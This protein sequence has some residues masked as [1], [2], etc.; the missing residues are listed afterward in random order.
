MFIFEANVPKLTLA[1]SYCFTIFLSDIKLFYLQYYIG[2]TILQGER[3][4][5]LIVTMN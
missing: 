5:N 2:C 1:H 3:S 4:H